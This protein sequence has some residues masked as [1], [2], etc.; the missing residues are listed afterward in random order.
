MAH[1]ILLFSHDAVGLGH[2]RRVSAIATRLAD[3]DPQSTLLVL[4]GSSTADVH[5]LP[6]TYPFGL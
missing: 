4:T 2:I 6:D 3:E 5:G 1:R